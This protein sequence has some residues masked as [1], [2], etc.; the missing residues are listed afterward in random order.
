MNDGTFVEAILQAHADGFVTLAEG[1]AAINRHASNTTAKVDSF[2]TPKREEPTCKKLLHDI[3]EEWSEANGA[4]CDKSCDA[5]LG[6]S[7]TCRATYIAEHLKALRKELDAYREAVR[8]AGEYIK[9]DDAAAAD[10]K[11]D[12]LHYGRASKRL[13]V[14]GNDILAA[15]IKSAQEHQQ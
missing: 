3:C 2:P 13:M 12:A 14:D 10:P 11:N 7:D 9:S 4:T 15:A 6:H 8:V 5:T 1:Q